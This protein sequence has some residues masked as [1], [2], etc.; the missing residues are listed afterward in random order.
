MIRIADPLFAPRSPLPAPA[1]PPSAPSPAPA[2][3]PAEAAL[4][5]RQWIELRYGPEQLPGR[6]HAASRRLCV[7]ACN[8]LRTFWG[9]VDPRLDAMDRRFLKRWL[10]WMAFEPQEGEQFQGRPLPPSP[11]LAAAT[12]N[13][14]LGHILAA[15]NYAIEEEALP[16]L[17]KVKKLRVGKKKSAPGG[18]GRSPPCWPRR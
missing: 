11:G 3:V 1:G 18:R 9:G 7:T 8:H 5:V 2:M 12:A 16:S 4:T 10:A 13:K 17:R 14:N 6:R 15:L